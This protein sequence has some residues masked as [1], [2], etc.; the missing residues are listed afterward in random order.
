M[1]G[2]K[3]APIGI[4]FALN[5][6]EKSPSVYLVLYVTNLSFRISG[7]SVESSS[8]GLSGVL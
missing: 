3:M 7:C 5:M 6:L 1:L 8:H 4:Q 2:T